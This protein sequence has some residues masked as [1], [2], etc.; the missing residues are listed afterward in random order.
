MEISWRI[1]LV[2]VIF[3]VL[4]S[5]NQIRLTGFFT[6]AQGVSAE[7]SAWDLADTEGGSYNVYAHGS[8]E[9]YKYPNSTDLPIFYANFT[10]KTSGEPINGSGVGCNISFNISNS[11]TSPEHM[12]FNSS[13]GLYEYNRTF[14]SRGFYEWNVTCNGTS[15]GFDVLVV[16]DNITVKNSPPYVTKS[17]LGV[18]QCYEDSICTYN[19]SQDTT[20]V[21]AKDVNNLTYDYTGEIFEGFSVNKT[22]GVVTVNINTTDNTAVYSINLTV[23]DYSG[24]GDVKA[25]VFNILSVNDKPQF[26]TTFPNSSYQNQTFYHDINA[27]DEE[28]PDGPFYFNITFISCYK[29][30]SSP[31]TAGCSALFSINHT[32]GV[33]NRATMFQNSD[34]GNYTINVS[35][36][37]PGVNLTGTNHPPYVW[38]PNETTWFVTNFTVIDLNDRPF[39]YP[40]PDINF[41]QGDNITIIL[42]ATDIDNGTLVFNTT[43]LYRNLTL[44]TRN[45]S[46]FPI[47]GNWTIRYDNG[48]S[49]GNATINLTLTNSHVGNFTINLTVYDGRENGTSWILF[50]ISVWNVNDPPSL[51]PVENFS[52]AQDVPFYYEIRAEDIDLE[53]PYGDNLTFSLEHVSGPPLF[54]G[55]EKKNETTAALNFTANSSQIGEY[56]FKVWVN[57]SEN[58][59]DFAFMNI[60]INYNTRPNITSN[61]SNQTLSQGEWLEIIVNATDVDNDTLT[62]YTVTYNRTMDLLEETTLFPIETNSSF[63]SPPYPDSPT[64][65]VMNYSVNNSQVG[66]WTVRIYVKDV[67]NATDYIDVNFTVLNVNDPPILNFS[68]PNYTYEYTVNEPYYYKCD[69]GENTTDPD[70]FTPYGENLTY[71]LTILK[72][73]PY[74]GINQT[75]GL[76]NF[77]AWN[78]SWTNNSLNYTYELNISVSDDEGLIN[79]T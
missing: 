53:T 64:A 10:N 4:L 61:I 31:H 67:W 9:V 14:D 66:N 72:G 40:V 24:D 63:Y 2:V 39:I 7:L 28:T 48:T 37:D 68:C 3:L 60:T 75:T 46:L 6:S 30:F 17:D 42:N 47:A 79:W 13:S 33:I 50:N 71:N 21:D 32:T 59:T 1:M 73:F 56:I 23:R 8:L 34:V 26:T 76:I 44:Y 54:F 27:I 69:I 12:W 41:T 45:V 62:F 55:I 22:T 52:I 58:L 15:Q 57:D 20:D 78:N 43:T 19:F 74:F 11:W 18:T 65:G 77:T 36:T 5:I 38:Q 49:F 51:F 25:K 29:P 70:Q 35:V 16:K